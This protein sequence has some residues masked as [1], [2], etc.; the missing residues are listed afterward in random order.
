[1]LPA[2]IVVAFRRNANGSWTSLRSTTISGPNGYVTIPAGMTFS[3]GVQFMGL[4]LATLL[5]QSSV[6]SP[7]F[8]R[9]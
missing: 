9:Y 8:V 2:S 1:M 5:D 4:E 6:P 7:L 3:R